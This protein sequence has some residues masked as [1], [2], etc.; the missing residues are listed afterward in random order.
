[1]S[2]GSK[3]KSLNKGGGSFLALPHQCMD[4]Q[5]YLTLSPHAKTLLIDLGRQ[6]KGSNNGDLCV[7]WSLMEPRGWKSKDTLNKAR[8]ELIHH[9]WIVLTRQGGRNLASLYAI[10]W[11]PINECKGKLDVKETRQAS[12]QWKE[13]KVPF[14]KERTIRLVNINKPK[15]TM[16]PVDHLAT[17]KECSASNGVLN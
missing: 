1:M 12:N 5:N 4:H 2:A 16:E 15:R 3:R 10:T 6:Y 8:K 7:A 13:V 17:R 11:W 9:G 14:G